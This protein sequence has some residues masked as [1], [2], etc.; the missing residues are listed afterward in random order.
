MMSKNLAIVF[1]L[2]VMMKIMINK[3]KASIRLFL[4]I[5]NI[6]AGNICCFAMHCR[7][8]YFPLNRFTSFLSIAPNKAFIK[9]SLRV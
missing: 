8:D 4:T 6:C 5:Y 2:A 7:R 3:E 9:F 1:L